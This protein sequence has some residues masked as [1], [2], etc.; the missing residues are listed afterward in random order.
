MMI[1][2]IRCVCEYRWCL[3]SS[4]K[5][6]DPYS[7]VLVVIALYIDYEGVE[8][9]SSDILQLEFHLFRGK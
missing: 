4:G 3:K 5:T 7:A 2:K 8:M 9:P 6:K 1:E